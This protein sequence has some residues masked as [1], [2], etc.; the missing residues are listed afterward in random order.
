M[1]TST[2]PWQ[3][4][5]DGF[6]GKHFLYTYDNAWKYEMYIRN[7][8]TIDYRIH[9]GIVA[10]RWVNRQRAY[11]HQVA[12]QVFKVS[13]DEPT[14]TFVS[15]TFNLEAAMVHGT[16]CFPRWVV[17]HPEKTV[18]HQNAVLDRMLR[19]RDAGPTYAKSI[20]DHFA[21]IDFMRDAGP[22]ND[23]VI[24]CPPSELPRDYPEHLRKDAPL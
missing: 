22:D 13:W 17:E 3:E 12:E 9:S 1:R 19:Y 5:L 6:V 21:V 14:G 18:C 20:E 10:G 11:M 7:A 15:L 4:N 16:V 8:M 2:G 23:A 24:A